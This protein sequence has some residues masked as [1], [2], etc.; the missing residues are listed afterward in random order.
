MSAQTRSIRSSGRWP[1]RAPGRSRTRTLSPCSS[2]RLTRWLPK[3][4]AQRAGRRVSQDA[5]DYGLDRSA[6][7][8]AAN[9][10]ANDLEEALAPP[11]PEEANNTVDRAWRA[12]LLGF[13]LPV[14]LHLYSL[15]LVFQLPWI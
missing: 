12:A 3:N 7:R 10:H 5:D 14:V 4:L 9:G 15:W 6:P 2:R 1:I 11:D 8:P 13:L